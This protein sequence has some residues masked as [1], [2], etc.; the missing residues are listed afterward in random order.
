MRAV[1]Q[2]VSRA[3]VRVK[4][5]IPG[6]IEQGF[7]ILLGVHRDDVEAFMWF[8]LAADQGNSDAADNRDWIAE[9]MTRDQIA[10]APTCR[11]AQARR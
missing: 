4:A 5:R 1:I 6:E 8:Q 7:V 3:K 10:E 2:R 9:R 11:R